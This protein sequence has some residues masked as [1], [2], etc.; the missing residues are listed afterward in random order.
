MRFLLL[1]LL[2][3][4]LSPATP[5][6]YDYAKR[7][8]EELGVEVPQMDCLDPAATLLPITVGG[9]PV[10]RMVDRCDKPALLDE[11]KACI[12]GQRLR[13]FEAQN[14]RGEKVV[15]MVFCRRTREAAG[16]L[17]ASD[18]LTHPY[19]QDVGLIQYNT[20]NHKTCWY[21][22]EEDSVGKES[23][24][25]PRPYSA[26]WRD[27]ASNPEAKAAADYW[28]SAER[29][30]R[31]HCLKCHDNGPWLRSPFVAQAAKTANAVPPN[32]NA[33]VTHVTVGSLYQGWNGAGIPPAVVVDEKGWLQKLSTTERE[34]YARRVQAGKVATAD[35]CTSCHRLGRSHYQ[36]LGT[37]GYLFTSAVGE[38]TPSGHTDDPWMP[39]RHGLSSTDWK[40]YYSYAVRAA[41]DCCQHPQASYCKP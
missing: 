12:P 37:C 30:D 33:L 35:T 32:P 21:F 11:N 29:T 24:K 25:I 3:C 16:S 2:V 14:A 9:Q 28:M 38:G 15:T 17:T 1:S 22:M 10:S 36:R 4:S 7:C 40:D 34:T 31:S 26:S 13:K 18:L 8:A 6:L 39:P 27:G 41:R 23:R 19:F 20:V 5:T